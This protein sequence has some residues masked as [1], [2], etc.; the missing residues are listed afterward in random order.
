MPQAKQHYVMWT[1]VS[2]IFLLLCVSLASCSSSTIQSK[3]EKQTPENSISPFSQSPSPLQTNETEESFDL[4]TI[5]SACVKQFPGIKFSIDDKESDDMV[6]RNYVIDVQELLRLMY[7]A[8]FLSIDPG[9]ADG[10]FGPMTDKAVRNYQ[11]T[12]N[13]TV[14][15]IVGQETWLT[16]PQACEIIAAEVLSHSNLG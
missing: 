7:Q 11:N 12:M 4:S 10:V 15:G 2:S 16:F 3:A 9:P 1:A 8:N 6:I 14:D 13:I 5:S